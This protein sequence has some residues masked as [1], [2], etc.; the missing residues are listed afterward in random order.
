MP[1]P[2]TFIPVL[3]ARTKIQPSYSTNLISYFLVPYSADCPICF[4]FYRNAV[5]LSCGHIYCYTCINN[6]ESANQDSN[7]MGML[8]RYG[9]VCPVCDVTSH[10]IVPV[11]FLFFEPV[12]EYVLMKR[13]YGWMGWSSNIS[14]RVRF[15]FN[16]VYHEE[17]CELGDD[18]VSKVYSCKGTGKS[19]VTRGDH[20]LNG[21]MQHFNVSDDANSN[22]AKE[23]RKNLGTNVKNTVG[24]KKNTGE[25]H[26]KVLNNWCNDIGSDRMYFNVISLPKYSRSNVFYQQNDGQLLFLGLESMQILRDLPLYIY[27]KIRK[28]FTRKNMGRIRHLDWDKEIIIVEF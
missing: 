12:D 7:H 4:S 20:T 3:S 26:K 21:K 23:K 25:T 15:P 1:F 5:T 13:V 11:K 24:T 10:V 9:I 19:G 18:T 28:R 27:F 22:T 17:N 2:D 16:T 8:G 14:D 6:V